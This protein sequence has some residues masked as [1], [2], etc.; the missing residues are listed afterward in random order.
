MGRLKPSA[1]VIMN[2]EDVAE[3]FS[4]PHLLDECYVTCWY[5]HH[6]L[7]RISPYI[8]VYGSSLEVS[9]NEII[10]KFSL[11]SKE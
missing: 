11:P 7:S 9:K 10:N 1:T 2:F 5:S 6:G 3:G 8:A 4:P